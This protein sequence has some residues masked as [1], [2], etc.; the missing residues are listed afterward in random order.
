[1]RSEAVAYR[2]EI[3]FFAAIKAAITKFTTVDKKRSTA[4]KNS[5]LKQILDNAI[6]ANGVSDIF[7]LA[8]VEKP[9]IGLLSDEF[10]AD[11]RKMPALSAPAGKRAGQAAHPWSAGRC[12]SGNTRRTSKPTP[13]TWSYNR[14][15]RSAIDG[16]IEHRGNGPINRRYLVGP[17][18]SMPV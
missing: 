7:A 11:V 1:V 17:W 3:A 10:L 8:G 5:A 4:E 13:S 9:D 18:I 6:L 2:K 16:A 14:P 15:K 12:R